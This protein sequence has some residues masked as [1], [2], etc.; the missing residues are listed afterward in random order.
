MRPAHSAG[1]SSFAVVPHRLDEILVPDARKLALRAKRDEDLPLKPLGVHQAPLHAGA[2]PVKVKGP[3]PV[4]V[5]PIISHHLGAG[6]F[7]SWKLVHSIHSYS[8]VT[9][10]PS[11]PTSILSRFPWTAAMGALGTGGRLRLARDD[12]RP[13]RLTARVPCGQGV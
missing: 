1:T 5:D 9:F 6:V 10:S 3:R 7:A 13:V 12:S 2:A 11:N 8:I 4:E